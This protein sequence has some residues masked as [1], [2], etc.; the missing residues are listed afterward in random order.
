MRLLGGCLKHGI[1]LEKFTPGHDASA[2]FGLQELAA[3]G[4]DEGAS[5]ICDK[6]VAP[7]SNVRV[8]DQSVT[9]LVSLRICKFAPVFG[10]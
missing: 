2:E 3:V 9:E 8:E 7:I 1:F 6:Y 4:V 5:I 10:K